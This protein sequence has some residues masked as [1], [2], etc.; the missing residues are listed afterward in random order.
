MTVCPFCQTA[1]QQF[2]MADPEYSFPVDDEPD[3][4]ADQGGCAAGCSTCHHAPTDS[5]LVEDSDAE[6]NP[7][8]VTCPTCDEPFVPSFLKECEWCGHEFPD[9]ERLSDR[10]SQAGRPDEPIDPMTP[11]AVVT[12][13]ILALGG[14]VLIGWLLWS[15]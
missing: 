13:M 3:A 10:R 15:M 9:G 8:M 1:G 4:G 6:P 2:D 5:E 7:M 14:A 12:A 11:Q